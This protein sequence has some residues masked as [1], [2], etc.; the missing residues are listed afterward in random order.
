MKERRW[1][2]CIV[3]VC[4]LIVG[5]SPTIFA[6]QSSAD[7]VI[8]ST[9]KEEFRKEIV[10]DQ[11]LPG[12]QMEYV[13]GPGDI[14]AV[15]VYGEGDM[16]A[17]NAGAG[18]PSQVSGVF[19]NTSSKAGSG[20]KVRMDGRIS[21]VHIGDVHVAGMTLTQTADYLKKL[22]AAVF[23]DPIITVVLVQ[24]NSRRYTVMGEVKAPGIFSLDFPVTIIQA[25]ARSGGFTEWAK[26]EVTVI[27]QGSPFAPGEKSKEEKKSLTFDYDDFLKGRHLEDNIYIQPNDVII[28]H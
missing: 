22:Y 11:T 10:G 5:W 14:V 4:C 20:I 12:E 16:S 25:V 18:M 7:V 1:L 24:S 17:A 19:G 9:Q 3:A 2:L 27:R 26:N 28:I 6:A 15:S 23:D 21:L 8:D 13:I